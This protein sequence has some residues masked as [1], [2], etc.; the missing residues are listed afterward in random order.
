M[1]SLVLVIL[2]PAKTDSTSLS[3]NLNE[4]V[5]IVSYG[6]EHPYWTT[7]KCLNQDLTRNEWKIF[8]NDFINSNKNLKLSSIAVLTC[9]V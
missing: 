2:G 3:L 9:L 6:P 5:D 8:I 1:P 7:R 4:Y